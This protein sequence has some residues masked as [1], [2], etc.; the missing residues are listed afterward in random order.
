MKLLYIIMDRKI[1]EKYIYEILHHFV[2]LEKYTGNTQADIND[3][4]DIW[5][6]L[7]QLSDEELEKLYIKIMGIYNETYKKMTHT[8]WTI[9][10]QIH[11]ELEQSEKEDEENILKQFNF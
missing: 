2:N 6:D 10:K 3:F 8:V 9:K 4:K 1:K 7:V 11:S 5:N